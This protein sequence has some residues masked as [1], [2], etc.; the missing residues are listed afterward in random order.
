MKKFISMLDPD[1]WGGCVDV[2][3]VIFVSIVKEV[4]SATLLRKLWT[5][6]VNAT[7][8]DY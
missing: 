4:T 5:K 6:K 3:S 7:A 2:G 8:K 1:R